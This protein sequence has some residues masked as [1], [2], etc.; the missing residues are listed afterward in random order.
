[1]NALT[2]TAFDENDRSR[3]Q[4]GTCSG[5]AGADSGDSRVGPP[6]SMADPVTRHAPVTG[7]PVE[8]RPLVC[9]IDSLD[10]GLH[11]YTGEQAYKSLIDPLIVQ[12]NA[13]RQSD[14][15]I[16]WHSRAFGECLVYARGKSSMHQFH[17]QTD[18]GHYFFQAQREPINGTPNVLVSINARILWLHGV[19]GAIARITERLSRI[20]GEVRRVVPSRCDLA[21]D[22]EMPN[23]I[24]S[25]FLRMH[26]VCKSRKFT[27]YEEDDRLETC[28]FGKKGSDLLF[29][30]YNK[31]LEIARGRYEKAWFFEEVWR[32]P[33]T[34][35]VWRVEGQIRRAILRKF[36]V[37][38]I[39]DLKRSLNALWQYLTTEWLSFRLLDDSNT[40]RRTVHPWW[41]AVQQCAALFGSFSELVRANAPG[42]PADAAWYVR[43][44]AGLCTGYAAAA[45][46]LDRNDAL[47]AIRDALQEECERLNWDEDVRRKRLEQGK[48][49]LNPEEQ[50][51][52]PP[53]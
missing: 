31:S 3:N 30:I 21:A 43:R 22:F 37:N 52:E 49:S 42:E 1:M 18:E 32:V 12:R 33:I 8:Y 50:D 35:T 9:G 10:V 29:R 51:D 34:S 38:S 41:L 16:L 53:F 15:P 36:G 28:Y 19:D 46:I 45:G 20:G 2:T 27:P 5:Q 6:P 24:T 11:V 13:A 23:G 40:A 39:D 4:S 44:M 47:D 17:L 26:R 25:E 48:E 14:K 7:G